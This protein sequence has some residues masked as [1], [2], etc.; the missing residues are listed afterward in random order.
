MVHIGTN[1]KVG[2]S[3]NVLKNYFMDLGAILKKRNSKA[4]FSEILQGTPR[5]QVIR[6][7]DKWLKN[8]CMKDG[9]GF[10]ENWADFLVSY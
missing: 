1:D 10:L 7:V 2:G 5:Q 3:W 9:F 8:W 6:K 4:V